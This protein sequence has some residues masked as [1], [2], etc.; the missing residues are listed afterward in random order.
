MKMKKYYPVIFIITFGFLLTSCKKLDTKIDTSLTDKNI[1]TDY[2]T[3]WSL[4][5]AP[6]TYLQS[7][8]YSIDNNLFATVSDEAE[9]TAS[10]SN[11]KL[12]NQ[13][14]WNAYNN[15]DNL[16]NHHYQ[17]I[18]AANYF[19]ENSI[20]YKSF[21]ALYRD[22]ISDRQLQYNLDV[23]DIAWLRKES[24]VLRAYY[25]FELAKRY[26][27]VPLVTNTLLPTDN[28]DLPR[29]A[30]DDIINFVVTEID[31]VKDS[32][33]VDWKTSDVSKAGRI[34][35]GAALAIKARALLY[36]AS[37]LHNRTNDITKWQKAASAAHDVIAL[38]QYSLSGNYQNLFIIDNTV[39]S[40]ESIWDI[41][42]GPSNDLEKQNY[43]I[44]T[45]GGNSGVT[46]SQ[47]LV[48]AYEYIG[49]PDPS[50]IYANR[51]P[52]LGSSI[53]MNNDFWNGR[54]IQ[55]WIG[56]TDDYTKTN[57]S[58]TGY[59]LK[60]FLNANL[61]LVNNQ[62]NL[63][64]WIFFRYAEILL[65][66]A[67]AMNEAYGPDITNGWGMT[68]R[69]AVNSVRSRPGV[70]MPA[71]IASSQ[72]QMRDKLKQERRIEFAFE[73]HRYWDLLRWKDAETVL[74]QPLKG[75]KATKN[76]NNTFSYAEITVE[77]RVFIA[78]KM[79]YY[80]IP[81]IEISKS[82]GIMIQN[83]GW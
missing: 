18:R 19:L 52:R 65:N 57:T 54:T 67:E 50:N 43:P 75:I 56:G 81:Q 80:P 64:S 76:V 49:T 14:G 41:R 71:V 7:G 1:L 55:T 29:A 12:F 44:G 21:L 8:F 38:N 35:R 74:N 58:K 31:A 25:Y 5:Y 40:A 22:T 79:Y 47:N 59:Y 39:F 70:T 9:Q 82:K 23:Q 11:A 17:A 45:P 53:V 42:L 30:F 24:R 6:Y 33:Q 73:D 3:L 13:G 34:T 26:G 37:P 48:S 83:P 46:P 51:D 28:T 72:A 60:K 10:S 68:A 77:N 78:P 15:P 2:N 20:N 27:G 16:Y 69:Q 4:G 63:R 61:D 62:S 66:Y 36:A 32:L